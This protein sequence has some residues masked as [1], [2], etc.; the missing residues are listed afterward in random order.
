MN[1]SSDVVAIVVLLLGIAGPLAVAHWA[2]APADRLE[3][4]H[5]GTVI[6]ATVL[7]GIWGWNARWA[8]RYVIAT[9]PG[10][11]MFGLFVGVWGF[12]AYAVVERLV[13]PLFVRLRREGEGG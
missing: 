13:V 6:F 5:I 1:H 7:V 4:K 11:A 3:T 9:R 10:A 2:R 8:S 12:I